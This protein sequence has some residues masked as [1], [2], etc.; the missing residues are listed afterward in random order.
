MPPRPKTA[1]GPNVG[2]R[3]DTH[4]TFDPARQLF[5]HEDTG[6]SRF[7]RV[8]C[9]GTHD[10]GKSRTD[11]FKII[12]I[13]FDRSDVRLVQNVGRQDFHHYGKTDL[14]SGANRVFDSL[15]DQFGRSI[16]A[17]LGQQSFLPLPHPGCPQEEQLE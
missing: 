4:Q 10:I 16:D 11:L 9:D 15:G 2:S 17:R 14:L 13:E 1:T 12:N 6:E 8:V 3:F 7:R 5:C